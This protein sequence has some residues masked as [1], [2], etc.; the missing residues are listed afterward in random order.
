MGHRGKYSMLIGISLWV[1]SFPLLADIIP[2]GQKTVSVS[3]TVEVDPKLKDWV[4]FSVGL[5]PGGMHEV[6][7]GKEFP[8]FY[9]QTEILYAAKPDVFKTLT[10]NSSDGSYEKAGVLSSDPV[11]TVEKVVPEDNPTVSSHLRLR[12][13]GVKGN[14]LLVTPQDITTKDYKGKV[15]TK[16][17]K[18][19][20]ARPEGPPASEH[21]AGP[22]LLLALGIFVMGAA[23]RRK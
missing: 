18:Q 1:A 16:P 8:T 21:N 3:Y 9:M 6:V 13:T 5:G 15:E 2:P 10:P 23:Y 4:F 17:Y 20:A 11:F 19:A 22:G 14:H 12:V 7:P